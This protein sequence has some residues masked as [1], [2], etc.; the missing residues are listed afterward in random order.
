MAANLLYVI[1]TGLP[2]ISV[3]IF[4]LRLNPSRNFRICTFIVLGLT[5]AYTIG[6]F[7][8]QLFAC[9]PVEKLWKPLMPGTCID[10]R[11]IFLTLPI[12]GTILDI[13]TLTLP[14][15]MLITLHVNIRT[16]ILLMALFSVCSCTVILSALRIWST[17][18]LLDTADLNWNAATTNCFT[19][20]EVN[21]MIVCGSVLV[22]R[23]FCRRHLPFLLGGVDGN[24]RSS[25][26]ILGFGGKPN[27]NK[28]HQDHTPNYDGPMGPRSKNE[29]R[30]KVRAN[31]GHAGRYRTGPKRGLWGIDFKSSIFT[32]TDDD[33]DDLEGLSAELRR[34]PAVG[35]KRNTY[36]HLDDPVNQANEPRAVAAPTTSTHHWPTSDIDNNHHPAQPHAGGDGNSGGGGGHAEPRTESREAFASGD[37]EPENG[38]VKTVSLDVR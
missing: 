16:K 38:I 25:N 13:L 9:H 36:D 1:T 4:Y 32:T 5:F 23:P 33:D 35:M 15:P 10:Q 3:L 27:V 22:L 28:D 31:G 2:R 6:L 19:V 8:V 18:K 21:L 29:Y 20:A 11:P 17:A 12:V 24:S 7:L 14:I 34:L 26:D 30:A 37:A